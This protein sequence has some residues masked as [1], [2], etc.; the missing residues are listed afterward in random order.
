MKNVR[1]WSLSFGLLLALAACGESAG[2]VEIKYDRDVCENC[3]MI[4]STPRYAAQLRTADGKVHK[5][6][7][8]G[9]AL[10]WLE[11]Q[12]ISPDGTKEFWVM[13]SAEGKT[14]LDARKAF[15]ARGRS[16]MNYNFAAVAKPAEGA[17]DF[18]A[19]RAQ[20]VRKN[21]ACEQGR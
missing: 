17:V 2:P 10:A 7:D 3:G 13:D 12:C 18:S 11:K 9:D 14:W 4:I 21:P 15:Y 6:D 5:F 20:A 16:P 8:I 1:K 19:M